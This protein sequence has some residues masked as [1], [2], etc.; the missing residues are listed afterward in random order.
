MAATGM[1]PVSPRPSNCFHP[2]TSGAAPPISPVASPNII[3]H[4]QL[5]HLLG[6]STRRSSQ[7][8]SALPFGFPNF[9]LPSFGF[10]AKFD[11]SKSDLENGSNS[12][13][14]SSRLHTQSGDAAPCDPA[15][16]DSQLPSSPQSELSTGPAGP[17]PGSE[18]RLSLPPLPTRLLPDGAAAGACSAAVEEAWQQQQPGS[19]PRALQQRPG[20]AARE[21]EEEAGLADSPGSYGGQSGGTDAPLGLSQ[22]RQ[23]LADVADQ[24]CTPAPTSCADT[25][26]STSTSSPPS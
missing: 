1:T 2:S 25:S 18:R 26:T 22:L 23:L 15:H 3:R 20:V 11:S 10:L 8:C 24:H 14:G 17:Q 6:P 12:S 21:V 4:K 5:H 19:G 9:G 16:A 7:A 13:S